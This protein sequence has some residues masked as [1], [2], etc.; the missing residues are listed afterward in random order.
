MRKLIYLKPLQIGYTHTRT[1]IIEMPPNLISE[2]DVSNN[3]VHNLH[4]YLVY[5]SSLL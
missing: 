5:L 1:Y 3:N 2:D 4:T